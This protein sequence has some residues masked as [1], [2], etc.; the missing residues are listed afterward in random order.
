MKADSLRKVA[1]HCMY[2]WYG[3]YYCAIGY[4][5]VQDKQEV[6]L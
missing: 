5:K 2:S 1:T 6:A 4:K 3:L